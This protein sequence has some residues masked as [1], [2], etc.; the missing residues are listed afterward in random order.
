MTVK[1]IANQSS[2]FFMTHYE[3]R[4]TISTSDVSSRSAE[5]LDKMDR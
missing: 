4:D 1:D 5:T 2:D 3:W